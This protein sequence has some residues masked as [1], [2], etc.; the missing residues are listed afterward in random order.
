MVL[1]GGLPGAR[2]WGCGARRRRYGRG[3]RHPV[4]RPTAAYGYA[5]LRKEAY[6]PGELTRWAEKFA[7]QGWQDAF[8]FFKHEDEGAGPALAREFVRGTR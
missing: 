7:D 5:R 8:V 6:E 1:G 3:G 2:R 4:G